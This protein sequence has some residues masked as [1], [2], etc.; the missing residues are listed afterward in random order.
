M[1]ASWLHGGFVVALLFCFFLLQLANRLQ[2]VAAHQSYILN[3][4][5]QVALWSGIIDP[6]MARFLWYLHELLAAA[7]Q[8]QSLFATDALHHVV[9]YL[10]APSWSSK[11]IA[12]RLPGHRALL[13][14]AAQFETD[15]R[16]LLGE[17]SPQTYLV[18]LQNTAEKRPNG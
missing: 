7:Q 9:S 16:S 14:G 4:L 2:Q 10:Q 3:E 18:I 1:Y 8:Q 17:Q 6:G 5:P 13:T 15:I 11:Y 12:E